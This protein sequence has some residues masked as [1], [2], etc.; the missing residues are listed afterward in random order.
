ME[1]MVQKILKYLRSY[2]KYMVELRLEFSHSG[3]PKDLSGQ[4]CKIGF[5]FL[6]HL[7][8]NRQDRVHER[9]LLEF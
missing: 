2:D 6:E 5:I 1:T 8:G 3:G 9:G 7:I 4:L